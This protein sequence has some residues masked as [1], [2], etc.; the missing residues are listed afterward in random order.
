MVGRNTAQRREHDKR[1]GAGTMSRS[2]A[3]C[4]CCGSIQTSEDIRLEGQAGRL[5]AVITAV[6]VDGAS[7]KEYRLP[8]QEEVQLAAQAERS[9]HK[10]F[11]EL[12]FGLPNEPVPRGGSRTGGGSP[13][14]V[15]LYGLTRWRDLFAPRQLCALACFV[16]HTR[17]APEVMLAGGYPQEWSEA[18]VAYLAVMLDRLA[19]Q[20]SAL[21]RW[22]QAGEIIEGTFARFALPILWDYAEVNPL[23][24]TSGGYPSAFEWVTL[25]AAH[26]I[27]AA[28][29]MP[30][31]HSVRA[32]AVTALYTGFDVIVT[33]PPYYDA[34][35][36]SDLMDFFHVWLR[37]SLH[38]VSPEFDTAFEEPTGP[39]WVSDRSDGELIDDASRFGGD[40]ARSKSAYEDGMSRAFCACH[41][42]LQPDGRLVVVF[43]HKTA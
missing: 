32:S 14:T 28:G 7:G 23:G 22:Y 38:S 33:D 2:G 31:P 17:S 26:L 30:T 5:G 40:K 42:S 11:A 39:K 25:A 36:Y 35:P 15:F 21:S 41:Q 37:R 12:P 18:V 13:F 27:T 43:A 3:A 34:I 16:R 19:N 8:T 24:K 4:P 9:L 1:L 20:S 29:G 10:F 6:V